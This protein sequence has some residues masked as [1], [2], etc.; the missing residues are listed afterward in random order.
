VSVTASATRSSTSAAVPRDWLPVDTTPQIG[1]AEFGDPA[2][3]PPVPV[4]PAGPSPLPLQ[5]AVVADGYAGQ[6]YD[7]DGFGAW[8]ALPESGDG[9]TW[10]DRGDGFPQGLLE[11]EPPHAGGPGMWNSAQP[12]QTYDHLSQHTDTSGWDLTVP[13][14]RV[15]ARNTFGQ[16]NPD[17]NPTWYGYSENVPM[18]RGA[19]G[20][21]PFTVD[22][23]A[24]GT[25]GFS[26]GGLPVWDQSG[27]QGNLAYSTPGPA[28]TTSAAPAAAGDPA[29]GWA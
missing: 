16:E 11:A 26:E 3:S 15:A 22:Q 4:V 8:P 21:A 12:L 23:Y 27:G 20:A 5:P 6:A 2:A 17:N 24:S 7:G 10:L 13:N 14:D 19:I 18:P 25:P 1:P 9:R 29:A 28:P